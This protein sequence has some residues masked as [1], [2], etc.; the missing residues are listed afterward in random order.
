MSEHSTGSL[1]AKLRAKTEE[2]RAGVRELVDEQLKT[3]AGELSNSVAGARRTIEADI[4]RLTGDA[5]RWLR[6]C[7]TLGIL[8]VLGVV[9]V[10]VGVPWW[11]AHD[12]G[13]QIV[14]QAQLDRDIR[15]GRETL[16]AIEEETWGVQFHED[17]NGRFLVLPEGVEPQTG[18]TLDDRT[19]VK[20]EER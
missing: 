2:S 11:L 20:L 13:D 14:E 3:L 7:V 8:G 5:R 17:A 16:R 12:I 15:R 19:A 1:R 4:Q 9:I 18:W 10:G 6:R